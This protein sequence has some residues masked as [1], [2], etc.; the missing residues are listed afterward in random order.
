[1]LAQVFPSFLWSNI[2]IF[3]THVTSVWWTSSTFSRLPYGL[4]T[5]F[6]PNKFV[7]TE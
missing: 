7:F 1:M 6:W 4:A 3:D 2:Q 5:K